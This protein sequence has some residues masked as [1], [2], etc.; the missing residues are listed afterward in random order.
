MFG[1]F[2]RPVSLLNVTK[3]KINYSLVIST[4]LKAKL[5]SMIL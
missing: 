2:H 4:Q 1:C 5:L 3:N